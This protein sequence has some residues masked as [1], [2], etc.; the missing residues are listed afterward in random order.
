[1]RWAGLGIGLAVLCAVLWL[2]G[3]QHYRGCVE[4]AEARYPVLADTDDRGGGGY[5][6]RGGFFDDDPLG[7]A[8]DTALRKRRKAVTACS[9]LPL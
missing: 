7:I 5:L 2:A 9:R 1:M 6:D 4:A 8:P 3:G